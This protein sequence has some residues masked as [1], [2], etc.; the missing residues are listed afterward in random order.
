MKRLIKD[1]SKIAGSIV[2]WK[3]KQSIK[4]DMKDFD[5]PISIFASLIS[6]QNVCDSLE[7]HEEADV[8]IFKSFVL[9]STKDT[10]VMNI[11]PPTKTEQPK[12]GKVMTYMT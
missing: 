7:V 2:N 6:F 10:F 4:M 8:W 12:E 9:D 11:K 1:A 3:T 5:D